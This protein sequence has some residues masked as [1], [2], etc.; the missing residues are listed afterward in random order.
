MKF[1]AIIA[2]AFLESRQRQADRVIRDHLGF[3]GH[4][5]LTDDT[6]NVVE[7]ARPCAPAAAVRADLK[8][9]A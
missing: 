8:A 4:I 5:G 1:F 9:A 3:M 7:L 6:Q 2:Q